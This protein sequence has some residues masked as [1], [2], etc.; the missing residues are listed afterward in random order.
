MRPSSDADNY[1]RAADSGDVRHSALHGMGGDRPSPA[2]WR[3]GHNHR[4]MVRADRRLALL[5]M[6]KLA[7]VGAAAGFCVGVLMAVEG[8]TPWFILGG[9]LALGL[10]CG[11]TLGTAVSVSW[12]LI[13]GRVTYRVAD[14]SLTAWRGS[15]IRKHVPLERIAQVEFDEHITWSDL[16]GAGWLGWGSPIPSLLV[17]LTP[18]KDSWDPSNSA[19]ESLPSVLI[20]GAR[21]QR[22][23]LDLRQALNLP[24]DE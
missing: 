19:I 22:A 11:V 17:R 24:L 7:G 14:G 10:L 6:A 21:Q 4:V 2:R 18:T 23:L 1:R 8:E 13:P 9:P 16:V 3:T 20:A 15:S 12:Y 5:A